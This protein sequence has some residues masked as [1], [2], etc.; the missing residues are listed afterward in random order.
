[1]EEEEMKKALLAALALPFI[2]GFSAPAAHAADTVI[3]DRDANVVVRDGPNV[4]VR[5]RRSARYYAPRGRVVTSDGPV[6]YGW[7]FRPLDCGV[8]HYWN[9]TKCVDSRDVPPDIGPK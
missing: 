1:M 3:M 9:G 8:Y 7:S 4:V 5:D 2:A 6:V